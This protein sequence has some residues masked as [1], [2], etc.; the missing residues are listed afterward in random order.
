M[1]FDLTSF[2]KLDDE[3]EGVPGLSFLGSS[4]LSPSTTQ[5]IN[6]ASDKKEAA[7][8]RGQKAAETRRRNREAK[9]AAKSTNTQTT[10]PATGAVAG[11]GTQQPVH[12]SYPYGTSGDSTEITNAKRESDPSG[13]SASTPGAKLDAGKVD[14]GTIL[15]LFPRSLFA[16]GSVG[17]FGAAKYSLGG[18]LEVQDGVHRYTSA[19]VRHMLKNFIGEDL[20][21][22]SLMMHMAHD[23]WNALA[24]L[25]LHLRE[26]GLTGEFHVGS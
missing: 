3:A 19:G 25:E 24:K 14:I 13:K 22:D 2:P 11:G 20:D 23:A 5:V 8:T 16:V 18:F 26:R 17:Q 9:E 1:N 6:D 7:K 21:S 15:S 10:S 4:Q 12:H